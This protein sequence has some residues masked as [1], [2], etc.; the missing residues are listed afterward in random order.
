M[1]R[2][3]SKF[4]ASRWIVWC[5]YSITLLAIAVGCIGTATIIGDLLL[6]YV[7]I[8]SAIC[9]GALVL[10]CCGMLLCKLNSNARQRTNPLR[11]LSDIKLRPIAY[12]LGGPALKLGAPSQPPFVSLTVRKESQTHATQ[13]Q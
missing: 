2:H 11:N 7:W 10:M 3:L 6:G 12:T 13:N 1:F 5:V 4:L 8:Y 9:G